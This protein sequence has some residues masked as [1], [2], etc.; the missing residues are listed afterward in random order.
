MWRH[1]RSKRLLF[2]AHH[3]HWLLILVRDPVYNASGLGPKCVPLASGGDLLV[4][5]NFVA[6]RGGNRHRSAESRLRGAKN[7]SG[8]D[9]EFELQHQLLIVVQCG[10]E[11]LN[12]RNLHIIG[13]RISTCTRHFSTP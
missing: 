7:I 5:L 10:E 13:L 11:P 2:E 3:A 12:R 6:V 4:W 1:V 8:V 9:G